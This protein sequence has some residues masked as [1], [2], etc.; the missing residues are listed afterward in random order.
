MNAGEVLDT[1]S[2]RLTAAYAERRD[3]PRETPEWKRADERIEECYADLRE[4]NEQY[5]A[6][7][8]CR[9]CCKPLAAQPRLYTVRGGRRDVCDPCRS[10]A[11]SEHEA[12]RG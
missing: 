8:M 6:D 7:A 1:I 10:D 12:Q 3:Q 5:A 4:G 9:L 2:E 11:Q